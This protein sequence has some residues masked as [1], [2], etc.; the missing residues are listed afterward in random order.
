MAVRFQVMPPLSPEEYAELEADIKTNGVTCPIIT[1]EE[2]V[3]IDGH[4]RKKIADEL[5]LD[6]PATVKS[7][8]S[9]EAKRSM[10]FSLNLKRRHL[11]REQRRA[12]IAESLKADPQLSN[13]EHARRTGVSDKTVQKLREAA[14][15][16]A[17]IPHFS[18]RVD[19]R[20]GNASQA[21]QHPRTTIP[22]QYDLDELNAPAPTCPSEKEEPVATPTAVSP[23]RRLTIDALNAVNDLNKVVRK[24]KK[25]MEDQRLERNKTQIAECHLADLGRAY[26]ALGRIIATLEGDQE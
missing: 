21:A 26:E 4:H 22:Q 9:V 2:G 14:E 1:D 11:N 12:L 18:R 19:P 17:E 20:T 8:L 7:G 23:R 10:A 3:I 24:W 15:E 16:S 5:G 6:C 13:R 25:I